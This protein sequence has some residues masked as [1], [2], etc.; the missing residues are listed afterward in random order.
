MLKKKLSE[1]EVWQTAVPE[2]RKLLE[3]YVD[4]KKSLQDRLDD[5]LSIQKGFKLSWVPDAA[6]SK[7]LNCEA[8]FGMLKWKVFFVA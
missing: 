6:V 1:F 5:V 2:L 4:E 3:Q 7:C 8:D